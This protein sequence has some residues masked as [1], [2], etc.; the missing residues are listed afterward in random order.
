[1]ANFYI[2]QLVPVLQTH[3]RSFLAQ[4]FR[5]RLAAGLVSLD[6]TA[7]WLQWQLT[8]ATQLDAAL[9]QLP[10]PFG[11]LWSSVRPALGLQAVAT[12]VREAEVELPGGVASVS[13]AALAAGDAATAAA[14]GAESLA[15]PTAAVV[16]SALC[17]LLQLPVRLDQ[18]QPPQRAVAPYVLPEVFAWDA[19]RLARLR[20]DV[21]L[22]ALQCGITL[23]VRQMLQ[24]R[25][26]VA[27][28]DAEEVELQHRLDV[29]LRGHT[30]DAAAAGDEP[31]EAGAG[32]S[33]EH[34]VAEVVRY[35]E[36]AIRR[37]ASGSGSG[38]GGTGAGTGAGTGT[39]AATAA[40]A[41]APAAATYD[42]R[43]VTA[44]VEKLL[45]EVVVHEASPVLQL[46][47]KRVYRVL[48][49][50]CL[51]VPYAHK[52]P[53]LSLHSAAQTRNLAT[54]VERAVALFRHSMAVHGDVYR[55]VVR[56][57]AQKMLALQQQ[58]SAGA[59][60]VGDAPAGAG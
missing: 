31:P 47:T 27:H 55:E 40:T 22:I 34:L 20:D 59:R 29:L 51:G 39:G 24:Q 3:G 32:A 1:M 56:A 45:R 30:T 41:A 2:A 19:S 48:F 17:A 28:V 42:V 18:T 46:F 53:A 12:A 13:L 38:S 7:L 49:R 8:P 57:L 5:E 9:A 35:A 15:T 44:V 16:A 6:R 37:A 26:R 58:P 21:D 52:L 10:P 33:L 54:L 4:R 11:Q 25:Y 50:A 36:Y 23:S 60:T 43:E 14:V